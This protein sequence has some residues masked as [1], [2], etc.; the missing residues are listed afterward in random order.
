[1]CYL[2]VNDG[3]NLMVA[4]VK[5]LQVFLTL[6]IHSSLTLISKQL[7]IYLAEYTLS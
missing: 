6:N 3:F 2:K 1:M 4:D 7:Q 5:N